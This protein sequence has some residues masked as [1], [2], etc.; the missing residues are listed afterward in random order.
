MCAESA[1]RGRPASQTVDVPVRARSRGGSPGMR[2][3]WQARQRPE[4][5]PDVRPQPASDAQ[6]LRCAPCDEGRR[7]KP[8]R[9]V[10]RARGVRRSR[11]VPW[12]VAGR[13]GSHGPRRC[14]I[15]CRHNGA[16]IS[17]LRP[18]PA[19]KEGP[20]AGSS[21]RDVVRSSILRSVIESMG[22]SAE[23]Q[24]LCRRRHFAPDGR[25]TVRLAHF[26]ALPKRDGLLLAQPLDQGGR[27]ALI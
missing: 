4:L 26:P 21:V 5:N 17:W 20:S 6:L 25:Q 16:L 1:S 18:G 14:L 19:C 15:C 22:T 27:W 11:P 2:W 24:Y 3:S 12:A 7:P 10:V 23:R 8:S 13:D 9:A